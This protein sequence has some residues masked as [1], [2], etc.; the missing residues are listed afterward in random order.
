MQ[1]SRQKKLNN[2]NSGFFFKKKG[3]KI[4]W[5]NFPFAFTFSFNVFTYTTARFEKQHCFLIYCSLSLSNFSHYIHFY[6]LFFFSFLLFSHFIC[7]S[8]FIPVICIYIT[9]HHHHHQKPTFHSCEFFYS[10]IYYQYK[11]QGQKLGA[12]K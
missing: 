9:H 12:K 6:F 11:H 2:L 1:E 3:K 8:K 4:T 5:N 10:S 7:G